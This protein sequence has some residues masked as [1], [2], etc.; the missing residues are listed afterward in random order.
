MTIG[1]P[2]VRRPG[3]RWKDEP[4]QRRRSRGHPA[5]HRVSVG[6]AALV[7]HARHGLRDRSVKLQPSRETASAPRR[8]VGPGR[9]GVG[10]GPAD[11]GAGGAVAT[12]TA[13][14]VD[15]H[16]IHRWRPSGCHTPPRPWPCCA[17]ACP[18]ATFRTGAISTARATPSPLVTG[19]PSPSSCRCALTCLC[20]R[21]TRP[22]MP[23]AGQGA[24]TGPGTGPPST[25]SHLVRAPS[26]PSGCLP[27]QERRALPRMRRQWLRAQ[28]AV[29]IRRRS[30]TGCHSQR[31]RLRRDPSGCLQRL[32]HGAL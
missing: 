25:E 22:P 3:R 20:R 2:T 4:L 9:C 5:L 27:E 24:S 18:I 13:A 1:A 32:S 10:R 12:V 15:H 30:E 29:R 19:S 17:E 8:A 28:R 7:T 16:D 21:A 14:A 11:G 26:V 6:P 23:S 31:P